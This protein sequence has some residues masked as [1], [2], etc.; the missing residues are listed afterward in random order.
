MFLKVRW[1]LQLKQTSL[2]Q[3]NAP[4][5][6]MVCKWPFFRLCAEYLLVTNVTD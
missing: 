2:S 1:R 6:K 3:F 4:P 5:W